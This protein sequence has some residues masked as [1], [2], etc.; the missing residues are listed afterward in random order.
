MSH[1]GAR[2]VVLCCFFVYFADY[3]LFKQATPLSYSV[4]GVQGVTLLFFP[5][6]GLLADTCCTQYSFIKVPSILL[7]VASLLLLVSVLIWLTIAE[8]NPKLVE[9]VPW[10]TTTV[11]AVLFSLVFLSVRMF[12]AVVIQFGM[13]QM[14]EAS[15]V[16]SYTGTTGV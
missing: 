4:P 15:S 14:V 3:F 9:P 1:H 12:E 13:D 16:A 10:Y 6:L 11:A 8:I 7:F 2:I 5:L